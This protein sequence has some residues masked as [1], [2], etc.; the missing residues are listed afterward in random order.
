MTDFRDT[1]IFIVGPT[2]LMEDELAA[3]GDPVRKTLEDHVLSAV[4]STFEY[5]G[6]P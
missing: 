6:R 3:A 5:G 2:V 1:R 4:E